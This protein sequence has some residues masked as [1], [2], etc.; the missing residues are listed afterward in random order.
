MKKQAWLTAL[1]F[2]GFLTSGMLLILFGRDDPFSELENRSLQTRPQLTFKALTEGDFATAAEA[3]M[4][5]QLPLRQWLVEQKSAWEL[6]LGRGESNGILLGNGQRLAR[7]AEEIRCANGESLSSLDAPDPMQVSEACQGLC[8]VSRLLGDRFTVLL[9][10]RN[11]DVCA[12]AFSY[13]NRFGIAL[14]AQLRR[15]LADVQCVDTLPLLR[16]RF[17]VGEEVYFRTD[18]HWTALG[19]YY[20]YALV[21]RSMGMGDEIIPAS[22]FEKRRVSEGFY[23]SLWSA[24]GMHWIAPDQLELW[25]LGDEDCYT[26]TADGKQLDGFYSLAWLDRR[27]H[28]SVFLDGT[29]DVVTVTKNGEQR[30]R[31]LLV[32]DSFANSMVPFL[33]HHFDL[34]LLNLSSAR[35]D[36][37]N[38]TQ[39]MEEWNADRCLLVYTVENLIS[40]DKLSRLR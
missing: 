30:P 12:S 6:A 21:M 32:K 13:P 24:C 38:V 37:T 23:G 18:H 1:L 14:E 5:D 22:S 28:Y 15:E 26:V 11:I 29:H 3:W 31:L 19:A 8:R 16:T 10:G 7:G 17:D 20:A 33:A 4:C 27:D 39:L 40:T 36:F 2:F 35:Q 34:I 25:Y 9:T